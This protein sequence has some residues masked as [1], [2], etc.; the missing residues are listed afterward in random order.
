MTTNEITVHEA[1]KSVSE[2]CDHARDRDDV[3]F[4][5]LDA[6]FANKMAAL[7]H[8]SLKQ[9]WYVA[10]FC[11]KYRRQVIANYESRGAQITQGLKGKAKDAAI[12]A[13]VFSL[14]WVAQTEEN[15]AASASASSKPTKVISAACGERSGDLKHFVVRFPYNYAT[16]EAFKNAI[17]WR[18]RKFDKVNPK[19]PK[20]EVLAQ[21]GTVRALLA[22]ATANG[23]TVT[24]GAANAM[25]RAVPSQV[26]A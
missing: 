17:D 1:L 18:D 22:F 16:V 21:P 3:G 10:R 5:G 9:E 6:N 19:D 14:T 2:H 12:K 26:A 24:D 7:D 15:M 11:Y 25:E 20:W 8:L 23:F 4:S 13:F